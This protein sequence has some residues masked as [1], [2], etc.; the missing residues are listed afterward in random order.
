MIPCNS[1]FR[2]I[3]ESLK[4]WDSVDYSNV[5][6]LDPQ[7]ES[8]HFLSK[9]LISCP[10]AAVRVLSQFK[11]AL[12]ARFCS[13]WVYSCYEFFLTFC[14]VVFCPNCKRLAFQLECNFSTLARSSYKAWYWPE[15][16][17]LAT[18]LKLYHSFEQWSHWKYIACSCSCSAFAETSIPTTLHISKMPTSTYW[19]LSCKSCHN[20]SIEC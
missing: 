6:K 16:W 5:L 19:W 10:K 9:N 7:K 17:K 20:T 13:Y 11:A 2:I 8:L 18:P 15:S 3:F 1:R 12:F 14:K 4:S